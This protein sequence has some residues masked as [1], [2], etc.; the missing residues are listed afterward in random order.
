[1]SKGS[2]KSQYFA[3]FISNNNHSHFS[4]KI[5]YPPGVPTS[6]HLLFCRAFAVVHYSCMP[7]VLHMRQTRHLQNQVIG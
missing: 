5:V 3:I 6:P 1:M 2:Q 7:C 4:F